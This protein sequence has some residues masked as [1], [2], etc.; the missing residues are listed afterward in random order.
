M[1]AAIY[2]RMSTDKQSE[3][4]PADQVR[5][6][7]SFAERR[8]L[9][10]VPDLVFEEAGISGA[11]RHNRPRLLELVARIDEWD[12]LLAFD[13]SRLARNQEDL[14][15]IRNRLRLHRREAFESSTGLELG[16]IG[17]RVMGVFSEE[18]LTKLAADTHRGLRGRFDRKLATG[19]CP[20]GYRTVA[21]VVGSDAHGRPLMDGFELEVDPELAPIVGRLFDGYALQGLGLR[22]LA[23]QLNAEGH[24]SPR[25]KG[26]APTAIREL[27]RNPIYRGER[28][29]NRSLWV[30]DHDTGRRR[31]IERP[32]SE[33]THQHEE[34]WRIVSDE[35]WQAAQDARAG[36]NER[37]ERDS[38][39][40]ILRS[41][42]RCG[43]LR[44]RLLSGFLACGECGGS[45]HALDARAWGCSWQRNR[46][47]CDNAVRV[48]AGHL[49][50]AVVAAV[51]DA[52][53]E[54][55]AEHAVRVALD[56]LEARLACTDRTAL[57]G[58]LAG[59]DAKIGRALDLAIEL[60]DMDAVKAKLRDLRSERERVAGE[61]ARTERALPTIKELEPLVRAR[62][63]DLRASLTADT[64]LGRLALGALLG[65]DR[66]RIYKDGRIEG[67]ATL[68]PE[69]LWAPREAS[70]PIAPVVAGAG[71]EPATCGL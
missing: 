18:Y 12:V 8:G 68:R 21:I 29:W 62:L 23:H 44:K 41:A 36:R 27:L 16:N 43:T 71:F 26:W 14:G 63:R 54:E 22:T 64:G 47:S 57:E 6:C 19:G 31:R 59:L 15:W 37:H 2:A 53:D 24:R 55:I 40:R 3:A 45:F 69:T 34:R 35:L 17:A 65:Q 58:S 20:F 51:E 13:F 67:T 56:E 28:V 50:R 1:R 32:E 25:G 11:S 38:G 9:D 4:S 48:P 52:L 66:L 10:V 30:K 49:E 5:E 7:R 39:G 61:L 46:G 60:G 33:W 70:E 42:A